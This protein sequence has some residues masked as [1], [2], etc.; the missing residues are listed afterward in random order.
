M[1]LESTGTNGV[2][3]A[4]STET[5]DVAGVFGHFERDLNVRLSTEIVDLSG[6]DL[7]DNIYEVGAVAQ[8]TI[9]ELKFVGP[10]DHQ[11]VSLYEY[12]WER[13]LMLVGVE[14]LQPVGI[15]TR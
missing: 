15:K 8:V 3:E 6:L 14:M 1:P 13:T 5:I 12:G 11:V 10:C 9:V 7:G 2:E 4:E